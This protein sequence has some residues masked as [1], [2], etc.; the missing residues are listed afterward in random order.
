MTA[1]QF[2]ATYIAQ[3]LASYMAARYDQDCQTGHQGQPYNHQPVE[4]AVF[5]ANCA[6]EQLNAHAANAASAEFNSL[7][8]FEEKEL[9]SC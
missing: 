8:A 3:F 1:A 4:D 7:F 6:W 2:K 9:P 5:L